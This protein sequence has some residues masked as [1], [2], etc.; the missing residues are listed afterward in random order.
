VLRHQIREYR[1]ALGFKCWIA[2]FSRASTDTYVVRI[3]LRSSIPSQRAYI[4]IDSPRSLQ[5]SSI[6]CLM[7]PSFL[8]RHS[9]GGQG[10]LP[11]LM[12]HG[13]I[14]TPRLL[15]LHHSYFFV[16]TRQHILGPDFIQN[17]ACF[18]TATVPTVCPTSPNQHGM[19]SLA[20]GRLSLPTTSSSWWLALLRPP[21]PLT[22][23]YSTPTTHPQTSLFCDHRSAPLL[24]RCRVG[25]HLTPNKAK[26]QSGLKCESIW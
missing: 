2:N 11:G 25:I 14:S 23:N 9:G 1:Y 10:H 21:V 22:H 20:A 18:P 15:F 16:V 7:A 5:G 4:L 24:H 3:Y 17:F 13:C 26:F 12:M 6:R 19:H 8:G